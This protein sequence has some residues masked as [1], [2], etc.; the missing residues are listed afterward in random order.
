MYFINGTPYG[1]L[2]RPEL[3]CNLISLSY[4]LTPAL[5]TFILI[6][7]VGRPPIGRI[8]IQRSDGFHSARMIIAISSYPVSAP[9]LWSSRNLELSPRRYGF[10]IYGCAA[11]AHSSSLPPT[12][13]WV[14]FMHSITNTIHTNQ[15]RLTCVAMTRLRPIVWHE[16]IL[17]LIKDHESVKLFYYKLTLDFIVNPNILLLCPKKYRLSIRVNISY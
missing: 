6:P 2:A 1:E 8:G 15:E 14:S 3:N 10:W 17:I 5:I 16:L 7:T 9:P 4:S 11:I 13:Y 12:V